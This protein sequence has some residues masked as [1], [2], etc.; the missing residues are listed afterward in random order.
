[1]PNS[2]NESLIYS[3]I[4]A[5]APEYL[6]NPD[7]GESNLSEDARLKHQWAQ[8]EPIATAIRAHLTEKRIPDDFD[9]MI[10]KI[11][12]Y[13][14]NE[15]NINCDR[16][17]LLYK[18]EENADGTFKLWQHPSLAKEGSNQTNNYCAILLGPRNR[19]EPMLTQDEIKEPKVKLDKI[20]HFISG[21]ISELKQDQRDELKKLIEEVLGEKNKKRS[22]DF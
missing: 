14:K 11:K 18:W 4:A 15:L 22:K 13:M 10:A 3:L 6:Q 5:F 17:I 7:L 19:Y 9:M 16:G 2:N 12:E 20:K 21:K 8:I 1:M